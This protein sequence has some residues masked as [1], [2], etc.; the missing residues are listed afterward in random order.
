MIPLRMLLF[1]KSGSLSAGLARPIQLPRL[2]PPTMRDV[3]LN[4]EGGLMT[5]PTG[6]IA[7]GGYFPTKVWRTFRKIA[8]GPIFLR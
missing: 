4:A 3:P 8:N 6:D 5:T 2:R 7:G 1:T